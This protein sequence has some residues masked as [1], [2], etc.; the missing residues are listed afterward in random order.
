VQS[1]LVVN[2]ASVV[3]LLQLCQLLLDLSFELLWSVKD[4]LRLALLIGSITP[5]SALTGGGSAVFEVF[6]LIVQL[7]LVLQLKLGL[8]YFVML[9]L[10]KHILFIFL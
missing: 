4:T 3:G 7:I 5:D 1:L 10:V 2:L 9:F 8:Q 6:N